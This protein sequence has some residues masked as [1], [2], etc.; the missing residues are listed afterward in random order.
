DPEERRTMNRNVPE[1]IWHN[2]K[3]RP[4]EEAT[5]HVTSETAMRAVNV[6]EGLRAYRQPDG[7]LAV[8]RLDAHLE[9]L[10]T[11]AA[12]MHIPY[13]GLAAELRDGIAQLLTALDPQCDVYVRP[14]VYVDTGRYTADRMEMTTGTIVTCYPAPVRPVEPMRCI[15]SSRRRIADNALP[16][17]AKTG[18]AYSGFRLARLEALTQGADEAILL[19]R[20]GNVAETGG[21]AVFAVRHGRITTPPLTDGILP[22]ITRATVLALAQR[23]GIPAEKQSLTPGDLHGAD[24]V[25]VTGTLDEVRLVGQVD[26][27]RPRHGDHPIGSALREEYLAMCAGT[28]PALDASFLT[29]IA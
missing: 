22:S 2:G 16:T 18:A 10:E 23:L 14:S 21:A 25:F 9:R 6:F 15:V 12:L 29:V 7:R 20:H 13:P 26:G 17:A 19:N 1:L 27:H 5:V 28:R 24:E 3:V 4:W 8:V 11:S